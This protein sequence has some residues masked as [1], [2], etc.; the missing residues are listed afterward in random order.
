MFSI[1][2]ITHKILNIIAW[3]VEMILED[4]LL[5]NTTPV[6]LNQKPKTTGLM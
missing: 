5:I 2:L 4:N 6:I 1:S 3:H